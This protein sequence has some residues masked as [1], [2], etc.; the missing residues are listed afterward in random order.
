[1]W[2]TPPALPGL[3]SGG[4][5]EPPG[6]TALKAWPTESVSDPKYF[7]DSIFIRVVLPGVG[8][9]FPGRALVDHQ[10]NV[11]RRFPSASNDG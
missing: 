4:K 5:I 6:I 7:V 3:I 8:P 2:S 11:V 10:T 9:I 1:M